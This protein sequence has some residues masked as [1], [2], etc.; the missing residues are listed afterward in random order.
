MAERVGFEPTK[1]LDSAL[2]K[3]AAI[4][5]SAT[6]PPQR[7][8]GKRRRPVAWQATPMGRRPGSTGIEPGIVAWETTSRVES[9]G[10]RD[11]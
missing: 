5:R 8:P 7:I 11:S 2:F 3:S 10:V 9:D 4:N 6:S 1:S